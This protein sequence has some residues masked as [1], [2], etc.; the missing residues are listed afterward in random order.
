MIYAIISAILGT[1]A[2][3]PLNLYL[4]GFIFLVPFFYYLYAED[5]FW[6]IFLATLLFRVLFLSGSAYYAFEPIMW[7][8][9]I[10]IFLA[11]ALM[12]FILNRLFLNR[13][14]ARLF[15]IPILFLFFDLLQAEYSALPTYFL[16]LGNVLGSS[17]FVGLAKHG[18]LFSLEVFVVLVNL[19]FLFGWLKRQKLLN[20]KLFSVCVFI[21]LG[22][23]FLLT[24]ALSDYFLKKS[25]KNTSF[26]ERH[27]SVTTVS[28]RSVIQNDLSEFISDLRNVET[29]LLLLPEELFVKPTNGAY[30]LVQASAVIKSLNLKAS[31]IV[32]TF[33]TFK[34]G[35]NYN[36]AIL[37]NKSGVIIDQYDKNKLV[38][39]GEY[40]PYN[41]RPLF[42]DFFKEDPVFKNY[43]VF[44]HNNSFEAGKLKLMQDDGQM[45]S[46]IKIGTLI[47]V[48]GYYES[49]LN[50]YKD[51]GANIILNP[52]SNNWLSR[53]EKQFNYL[54]ANLYR[55]ESIQSGLPI[56][57]S[58]MDSFAG[59]FFPN[60]TEK[61]EKNENSKNY[62]IVTQ[63]V[64][65]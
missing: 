16:T 53:G 31:Y 3:F 34:D 46:Q 20:E 65:Y 25:T 5:D 50:K 35:K 30:E 61:I 8:F 32:S 37:F 63:E 12:V 52:V 56:A 28:I 45:N 38:F 64:K 59:V 19:I 23:F 17:P 60:G 57:I 26:T 41:W 42:Y 1:L 4:L 10:S 55:I 48:E 18:G 54:S 9:S 51:M 62:K 27:L 24:L 14:Q 2:F 44:N 29:E 43:A 49:M 15:Y 58:G 39:F 47:C 40:W 21:C 22:S 7:I 6:K 11:L 36:T 33:H 13:R